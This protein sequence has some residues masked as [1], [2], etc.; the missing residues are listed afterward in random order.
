MNCQERVV[1]LLNQKP[2]DRAPIYDLLRNDAAI[3]HYCQRK[4]TFANAAELACEAS[5]Y[6]LDATRPLLKYPRPDEERVLPD[7][8]RQRIQRWTTWT[9]PFHFADAGEYESYLRRNRIAKNYDP[10]VIQ[11][12][13]EQSVAAHLALTKKLGDTFL[14]WSCGVEVGLMTLHTEVGLDQFSY[15]LADCPAVIAAALESIT[16][17]SLEK[18]KLVYEKTKDLPERPKAIFLGE[19]IAFK[20]ATMFAPP[21][22]RAE[23]FPRL[24]RISDACHR[25]GW[26]VM[27]HSDGYLM[28]ILDDLVAAG[29]DVLNPI[30]TAAKM[31]IREIH[32]RHPDLI[33]AGGID[34]SGLLPFGR[35]SEIRD[36]VIRAIEDAEGRIMVGSST[37]LHTGIPLDNV[38]ALYDTILEYK[39][40]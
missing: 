39:Y 12:E 14:F 30:E 3:E 34:V 29:V 22:F 33:L 32:R 17:A 35:P 13:V 15:Y 24:K 7:G 23:F 25:F 1:K 18:I 10:A 28:E 6:I 27:F 31:E 19:D 5:G 37:E 20:T 26:K 16:A 38:L 2:I 21:F 11:A 36:A 8:R 40:S 9:E 4:I